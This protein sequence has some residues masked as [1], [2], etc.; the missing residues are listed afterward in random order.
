M[1]HFPRSN[2]WIVPWVDTDALSLMLMHEEKRKKCDIL[3]TMKL[4]VLLN[5]YKRAD[6]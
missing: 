2:I 1:C 5:K 6:N 3:I 4:M